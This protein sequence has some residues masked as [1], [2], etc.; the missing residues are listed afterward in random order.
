MSLPIVVVVGLG[1]AGAELI[2]AETTELLGGD[3]PVFLRTARHP[4]AGGLETS[5]FDQLY[6]T[7]D[8]FDAV[9]TAIVDELVAAAER[10]GRVIYAVPGSPLVAEHTVELLRKDQRIALDIRPALSFADLAW[11]SLEVDPLTAAA[12][13][14]DAHQFLT[15]AA[16]RLGPLLITQVHSAEI[17]ADLCLA[18]DD[19]APSTVTLLQGLGTP[20]EDVREVE[21]AHVRSAISPDHLTSLWI[22][23]LAEPIGA[24]FI[25]FDELVRR[26]RAECPWDREQTHGSLRKHLLEET[27]EV[28]E[29]IDLVEDDP[30]NYGELEEELGDLLFQVFFHARLAAEQGQF[31]VA[32]VA[33]GIHDKLYERHPHV[34]GDADADHTVANWELNKQVEKQRQSLLDGI[35]HTLPALLTALK[36][37]K[38]AAATGFTGPDLD[39]ALADVA[40]ELAEVTADPTEHEVGDLLYA[41]VQVARMTNVD[42][43]HALRHAVAR[44]A[45]RFRRVERDAAERGLVLAECDASVL[46]EI[47]LRAKG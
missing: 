27:H 26:L 17:L 40:E 4:A 10:H 45:T 32:D 47:W 28:L 31:T 33:D 13:M 7:L 11:L 35:P 9:Y 41:A 20:N 30:A 6:E 23:R 44:F 3:E 8:S 14:V 39:W 16:G 25:R 29:A 15:D 1:P 21:W 37:Q 19:V 38:R 34:F 24:A 43:E 5:S 36:V 18:L 46:E 22:P 12:T 42:P 2:T